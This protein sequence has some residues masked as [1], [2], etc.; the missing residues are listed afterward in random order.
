IE[1]QLAADPIYDAYYMIRRGEYFET[2]YGLDEGS[3]KMVRT[4]PGEE[5]GV[6]YNGMPGA[7]VIN[8]GGKIFFVHPCM[9]EPTSA[10]GG[11]KP[12]FMICDEEGTLIYHQAFPELATIGG[13][14]NGG[15]INVRKVAD[16]VF[17]IYVF[18]QNPADKSVITA[19]FTLNMKEVV[20]PAEPGEIYL[21]GACTNWTEPSEANAATYADWKL[22]ET[23]S[24]TGIYTGSFEIPA[25][26]AMFRFYS[27]LTG[28]DAGASL[29]IAEG[30]DV[31]VAF[32]ENN[33]YIGTIMAGNGNLN[34]TNWTG[35]TMDITVDLNAMTVTIN[36]TPVFTAPELYV[37]GDFNNWEAPEDALMTKTAMGEDIY[38]YMITLPALSGEFKLATADWATSFGA[39]IDI[40]DN[41]WEQE[42]WENGKN[43]KF[44]VE[45]AQNIRI[46]FVLTP[47]YAEPSYITLTW[48]SGVADLEADQNAVRY[49]NL[50]GI[51]V[52]AE[53]L[54]TGVYLKLQGTTAT[55]V[56]VK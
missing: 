53:Q 50:Q 18:Q 26:K 39:D 33:T 32:D 31:D 16:D 21:V 8:Y 14:G 2:A 20:I 41:G 11:Y 51:E 12:G 40:K 38:M 43:M 35:G 6:W 25:N 22:A 30:G 9:D 54:T 47:N 24:E 37:R 5:T 42:V 17:E 55:K 27:E 48:T 10:A 49:F 15:N 1:E 4:T 36:A 44:N 7:D 56:T 46:T 28:W 13:Y 29:G 34:F 45:D 52:P 23:G 3:V 19:Y